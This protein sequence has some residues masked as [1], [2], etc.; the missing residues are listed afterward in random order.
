MGARSTSAGKW[1][2]RIS[3]GGT[4]SRRVSAGGCRWRMTAKRLHHR[5]A[6]NGVVTRCRYNYGQDQYFREQ[7]KSRTMRQPIASTAG[8]NAAQSTIATDTRMYGLWLTLARV[9]WIVLALTIVALNVI[10]LPNTLL[11]PLPPDEIRALNH[12]GFS[13]DLYNAIGDIE[14]SLD[15]VV[16]LAMAALLFWR[17]SYDRMAYF[18]SLMLLTF[19]GIVG[20]GMF[21]TN[22]GGVVPALASIPGVHQIAEALVVIAQSSLIMFFYLF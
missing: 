5:T 4:R 6:R 2:S 7:R 21:D 10:A 8:E 16:F 13:P 18:G 9:G 14:N 20:G 3:P 19:G 22:T 12:V 1:A 11:A 17:K 15:M